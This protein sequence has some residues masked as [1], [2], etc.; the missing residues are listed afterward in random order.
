M[1][2]EHSLAA[3]FFRLIYSGSLFARLWRSICEV[4]LRVARGSRVAALVSRV[5]PLFKV[6]DYLYQEAG[7]LL[8]VAKAARTYKWVS[9]QF[10]SEARR[11]K[12]IKISSL[13]TD[14]SLGSRLLILWQDREKI[15]TSKNTML[16]ALIFLAVFYVTRFLLLK[17]F[18]AGDLLTPWSAGLIISVFL[19]LLLIQLRPLTQQAG[20]RDRG[21]SD[22]LASVFL[23]AFYRVVLLS[24]FIKTAVLKLFL[25]RK[26][27]VEGGIL[28]RPSDPED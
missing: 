7:D 25:P 9:R 16:F 21:L 12:E 6:E 18:P 22:H 4:C 5:P 17:L 20:H 11:L 3:R 26:V 27:P 23:N 2:V 8:E 1:I 19:V 15:L 14:S 24:K 28:E 13:L 10:S